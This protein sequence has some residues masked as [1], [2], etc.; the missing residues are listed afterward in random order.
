[1][2]GEAWFH[3]AKDKYHPF[4]I[5]AGKSTVKVLGTKFNMNAYPEEKYVEVVLEEGKVE[6]TAPGIASAI[7]MK[8]DERLTYTS[9]SVNISSTE[10]FK[11]SAWKEG[12]LVFRGDPMDRSSPAH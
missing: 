11:Y 10:P 9:D 5:T 12:K 6:F 4:E 8:P 3:V 1:M 2:N 7:E